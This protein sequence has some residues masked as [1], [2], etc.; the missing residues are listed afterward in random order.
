MRRRTFLAGVAASTTLR[1]GLA[2][3]QARIPIADMHLHSYFGQSTSHLRPLAPML[4][5]AGATLVAW[6]LVGDLLLVDWKTYKQKSEPKSGEALG[7]FDRELARIKAHCAEQGLKTIAT[8]AD[9]DRAA[10]GEPRIVLAV[11]GATFADGDPQRVEHAYASGIRHLGL[12]HYIRSPIGDIQTLPYETRGLT[13]AG[14]VVV[15]A[16]NRLGILIDVAHCSLAVVRDVLALSTAPIV[17]SHGSVVRGAAAPPTAMI[18][19][20]RQLPLDLAK[21]IADKG[22][23]VGLWGLTLDIG[24]S[25]EDYARRVAEA[26]DWLGEDHVAFGS[27]TN[28]LGPNALISAPADLRRVVEHWQLEKLPESRIRKLAFSNYARVLKAAMAKAP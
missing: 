26:A 8:S 17:S 2:S 18:W 14:K 1:P 13:E 10:G 3:A 5:A 22:G 28:G 7:W 4:A 9:V 11:E 12:V 20:A 6:S 27:D 23:V 24:R 21:A 16:C 15:R 19:R 25:L